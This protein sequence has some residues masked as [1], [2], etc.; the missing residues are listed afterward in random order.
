MPGQPPVL[1]P[2]TLIVLAAFNRNSDGA[3]VPAFDPREMLSERSAV[4]QAKAKVGAFAG[5]VAWTREAK[6]EEGEFGDPV[7]LFRHG[8]VPEME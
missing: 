6:P 1:K 7:V 4:E 2:T 8:D 3:L 5:I